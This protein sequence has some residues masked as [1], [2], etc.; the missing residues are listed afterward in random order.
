MRKHL[1]L[2]AIGGLFIAAIFLGGAWLL[3][4]RSGWRD[5]RLGISEWRLPR[6]EA[7]SGR[8]GIREIA[9]SGGESVGVAIPATLRYEPGT[10]D[11][12]S[13]AGDASLIPHV[14][15]DGN[16]IKLDC[17]PAELT[18][19][20]LTITMPGKRRFQTFSLAGVT[21]L[22][23]SNIDQPLLHFN[24]AG[25]SHV[26]AKGR[27]DNVHINAAGLSDA[28][29]G[30]L[31][32]D[33]AHLNLAGASTVE[34]AATGVLE[35]NAAGAVTVILRTEPESIRTHIMGSGRIIHQS[36]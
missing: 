29:L 5:F 15:I 11:Q 10:G 32:V 26:V 16:D 14:T 17:R 25:S 13:I 35:V 6:C 28:K 23:L 33:D 1:G 31:A 18:P 22:M 36:Q 24:L 21:N 20:S 7:L 12:V 2:I 3:E 19:E 8:A 9:W 34:I 27:V 4:G 30:D